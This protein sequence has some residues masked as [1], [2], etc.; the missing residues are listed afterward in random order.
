M[1]YLGMF[2]TQNDVDA[3][4]DEKS[5]LKPYVAY[6]DEG[7]GYVDWN[8]SNG[9][10]YSKDYLTLKVISGGTI[11]YTIPRVEAQLTVTTY[12]GKSTSSL[13]KCGTTYTTM[14]YE[15][16]V[17][18]SFYPVPLP[19]PTRDTERIVHSLPESWAIK[20]IPLKYEM[21]WKLLSKEGLL[22]LLKKKTSK[23]HTPTP[24]GFITS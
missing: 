9:H 1:I 2:D 10:D 8:S 19:R 4:I 12:T 14:S 5:L 7:G 17:S 21:H 18:S 15:A 11:V 20:A 13:V 22:F 24:P 6:V 23:E 16:E 3:A